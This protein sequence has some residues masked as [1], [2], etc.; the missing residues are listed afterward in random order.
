MFLDGRR[1][2]ADPDPTWLGHAVGTWDGDTLVVD[3]VG[4]N[5]RSWIGASPHTETLHVTE[6]YHRPDFGHLDVRVTFD[7]PRTF[8][9]PLNQNLTWELVPDEEVLEFVCENNKADHLVGK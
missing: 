7:D 1:H 8:T 4:F 2:P 3:T 6:R 9:K 5:D